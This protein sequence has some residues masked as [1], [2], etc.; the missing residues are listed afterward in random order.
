MTDWRQVRALGVEAPG[1]MYLHDYWEGPPDPGRYRVNTLYTGF[2]AGTELTFVKGTNPYLRSRWDAEAGLFRPEEPSA[3]FPVPFLGY[4]E[5]GRVSASEAPS[6]VEGAVLG[7]TYGHKTGH[8]ADPA[9]DFALA[10]PS[11]VDP[12]LGIYLAQ[13][14]PICANGLLHAAQDM[15]G[16]DVRSLDEGVRGRRL[17]VFGGGVVGLLTALFARWC[18]A[19][20]VIVV[21]PAPERRRTAEA[22]GFV[23][24]QEEGAAAEVKR[25]WTNGA[26]DRGADLAFQCRA[27]GS[28][29]HEALRAL[30]PQGTVV[31]LAFYQGG[32]DAVRLGEEFHHNGLSLRCAQIG[33]VPRGLAWAWDRRRLA[34][35]TAEL[36]VAEGEAIREHMITDV[37]PFDDAPP[38]VAELVERRRPFVQ[39]VFRVGE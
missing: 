31:D 7:M 38:F 26:G 37:V 6:I 11:G 13:M 2:S 30:R 8:T 36:L 23:A 21:D 19:S 14:G 15:A 28:A 29:L 9:Q 35:A 25:R 34:A 27:A 5:V 12:V 10:V 18:G 3:S 33:R 17:L 22:L 16:A 20:E 32:A 24:L 4:M 1:R 39:V